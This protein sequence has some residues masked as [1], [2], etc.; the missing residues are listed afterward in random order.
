M[1]VQFSKCVT[2]AYYDPGMREYFR[3]NDANKVLSLTSRKS[4]FN[5]EGRPEKQ[6]M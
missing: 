5:G 2:G 3:K 1:S 6:M 4:G